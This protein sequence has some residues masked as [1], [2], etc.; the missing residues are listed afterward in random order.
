MLIIIARMAELVD[1]LGSGSS[2]CTSVGVQVP[3]RAHDIIN[4]L[5]LTN[6]W[7]IYFLSK[8]EYTQI[9]YIIQQ[10]LL[11]FDIWNKKPNFVVVL[12][13]QC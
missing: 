5:S 2:G 9:D 4:L 12:L 3:L 10:K 1:A 8:I 7:L 11:T 6:K 13:L